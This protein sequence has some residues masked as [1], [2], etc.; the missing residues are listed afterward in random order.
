M[1]FEIVACRLSHQH[2][3]LIL[4]SPRRE[5]FQFLDMSLLI[6]SRFY[7]IK[8]HG[9]RTRLFWDT[10]FLAKAH[11]L[12]IKLDIF[13]VNFKK[14]ILLYPE[15][16]YLWFPDMSCPLKS[17]FYRIKGIIVLRLLPWDMNFLA[18]ECKAENQPGLPRDQLRW[19]SAVNP[20][21]VQSQSL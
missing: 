18:R 21:R 6:E 17:C 7:G 19:C 16:F 2:Q 5:C 12:K 20:E 15:G 14:M 13:N 9:I 1:S 4:D 3:N 11:N 10:N 8:M